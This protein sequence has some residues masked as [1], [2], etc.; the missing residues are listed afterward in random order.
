[1]QSS[2]RMKLTAGGGGVFY[3]ISPGKGKN[4]RGRAKK[5]RMFRNRKGD[6][7]SVGKEASISD[8][9]LGGGY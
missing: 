2:E 7:A 1:L 4:F 6:P 3:W 8:K 5:E 9:P